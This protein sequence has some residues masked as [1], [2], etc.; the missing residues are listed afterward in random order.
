MILRRLVAHLRQQ[1]WTSVAIELAIVVLGVFIGLQVDNWNESR[2]ERVRE[3]AYLR[4]IAVELDESIASIRYSIE[5]SKERMALNDLVIRTVTDPEV[6][7][8]DP[9]RFTRAMIEGGYTFVPTIRSFTFEAIKS[10]GDLDVIRDRQL[11]LDLMKFHADIEGRAQWNAHR[12]LNQ[13]EYTRR[14]AGIMS[15]P[16]L[17]S[18]PTFRSGVAANAPVIS[19]E[20]AMAIRQK[21]LDRPEFIEWLPTTLFNRTTD[22]SFAERWLQTANELRARV[23][24]VP[25]VRESDAA[26]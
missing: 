13:S 20:E 1:Q 19:V 16:Q 15:A 17:L 12:A 8:T 26:R 3:Q 9:G 18:A 24:A 10:T 21:M 25:G 5:L 23:L 22:I 7:R 2:R 4:S 11:V 14:F 6:V